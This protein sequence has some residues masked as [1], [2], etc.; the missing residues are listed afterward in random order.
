[1]GFPGGSAIKNPPAIA[2]DSGDKDSILGSGR[3]CG[4]GNDNPSQYSCLLN[5]MDRGAW[6]A[7]VLQSMMSQKR[8]DLAAKQQQ[9]V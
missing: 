4:D 8:H 5:P 6:R 7:T 2:R 3:S 1:M 9:L